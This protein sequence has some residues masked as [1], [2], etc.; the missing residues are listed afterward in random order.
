MASQRYGDWQVTESLGEG[1]QAHTFLVENVQRPGVICVLK[2]LKHVARLPRFEREVSVLRTSEHPNVLRILDA[3]LTGSKPFFVAPFCENGSLD[4][5][6]VGNWALRQKLTFFREVSEGI[7]YAHSKGV[8]HR[9]VKPANIFVTDDLQ[10]VVGD[11]GICY[12]EGGE[13][14]TLLDEAVGAARFMA[15]EVENGLEEE[16]SP[17]SDVYSLGKLL[18][19]MIGGRSVA[20][21]RHREK[22]FDI[23]AK[24]PSPEMALV[25]EL[26]DK[27]IVEEVGRRLKDGAAVVGEIEILEKRIKMNAHVLDSSVPQHCIYCGIGNYRPV[28]NIAQGGGATAVHNFGFNLVGAPVWLILACDHCANIQVFRPDLNGRGGANDENWRR[29]AGAPMS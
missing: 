18:H 17:A 29:F 3:D 19:W 1:G 10:P 13:R 12:V 6:N 11:F 23:Y 4:R 7:A 27:L 22:A 8:V 28:V 26:L 16:V 20:R 2:R 25:N 21:E 5:L 24:S 9:D 15:P 14:H